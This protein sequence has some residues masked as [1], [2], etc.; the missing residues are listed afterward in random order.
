MQLKVAPLLNQVVMEVIVAPGVGPARDHRGPRWYQNRDPTRLLPMGFHLL[1]RGP[2]VSDVDGGRCSSI[3]PIPVQVVSIDA[4]SYVRNADSSGIS[5]L[6]QQ[7]CSPANDD[8]LARGMVSSMPAQQIDSGPIQNSYPECPAGSIGEV[9]AN[10]KDLSGFVKDE[11]TIVATNTEH[12]EANDGAQYVADHAAGPNGVANSLEFGPILGFD[13]STPE[14]IKR[15]T[16]K[17]SLAGVVDDSLIKVPSEFPDVCSSPLPG[18][19]VEGFEDSKVEA[20]MPCNLECG[21]VH[22]LPMSPPQ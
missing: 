5:A 7:E 8:F 3:K 14:S 22:S 17:Y 2:F 11:P 12:L 4:G 6:D 9:Y 1:P 16:R 10:D 20:V 18:C 15:I 13:D 21:L 19:S